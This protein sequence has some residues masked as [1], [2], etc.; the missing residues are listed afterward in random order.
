[1]YTAYGTYNRSDALNV[2]GFFKLGEC[3]FHVSGVIFVLT[4]GKGIR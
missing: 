3:A 2:C 4:F 1:M